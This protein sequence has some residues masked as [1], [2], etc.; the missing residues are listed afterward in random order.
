METEEKNTST[1]VWESNDIS[2][3]PTITDSYD[4]SSAKMAEKTL[5]HAQWLE[6]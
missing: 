6:H 3:I 5:Y 4:K 1:E 2:S